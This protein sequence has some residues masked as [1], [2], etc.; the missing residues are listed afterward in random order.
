[1]LS[2]K[3]LRSEFALKLL[4]LFAALVFS[5]S[6]LV[7][8]LIEASIYAEIESAMLADAALFAA[9]AD[10]TM[11]QYK[12]QRIDQHEWTEPAPFIERRVGGDHLYLLYYPL[13]DT[14]HALILTQDITQQS[15]LLSS[16]GR[17]VLTANVIS[18]VLIPIIA[19]IYSFF[20]ARPIGKLT[21]E[22]AQMDEHT[23]AE[24]D[25]QKLPY[26]FVPLAKTLNRLLMRIHS[27]IDYQR[28]L[29]IGVAHELK[30][31]LAVIRA[32][33]DVTLLKDRTA[34]KYADTLRQTNKVIDEMNKMTKTILEIGRA[35][36]A[37]FEAPEPLDIAKFLTQKISDF[38]L[39][40]HEQNRMLTSDITPAA[41]TV[42]TQAT[43]ISH[44]LQNLFSNALKFTPERQTIAIRSFVKDNHFVLEVIDEG[45]GI[46]QGV[47]LFAPFVSRGSHKGVGLG[48]YLAK[49][50]AIALGGELSLTARTDRAGA[51]AAFKFEIVKPPF[52]KV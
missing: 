33:N 37:Q 2:Q 35:E 48:L 3:S 44:I 26:E 46:A 6:Y 30:T 15:K 1:M 28:Q 19:L 27:H 41:L 52:K 22:L 24:V 29:F 14:D 21:A 10:L 20:L 42:Y 36:Y 12:V 11:P 50:A 18:L 39:L 16:I 23:I 7:Y 51:V 9:E 5:F 17:I 8:S 25:T 40:A 34:E 47:D 49:N 32:R 4:P 13:D 31:P 38:E 45:E 43:L